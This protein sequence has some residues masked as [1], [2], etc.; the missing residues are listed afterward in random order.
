MTM[1]RADLLRYPL[2]VDR[3]AFGMFKPVSPRNQV[4]R[5][6]AQADP[7]M[8]YAAS[9]AMTDKDLVI[10]ETYLLSWPACCEFLKLVELDKS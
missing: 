2:G 8:Q 7:R 5:I 9:Q 4:Q 1:S 3:P 6:F 10:E